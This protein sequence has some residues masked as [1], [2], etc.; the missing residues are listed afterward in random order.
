M[1]IT[2]SEGSGGPSP[3]DRGPFLDGSRRASSSSFASGQ[4]EEGG[5]GRS[6]LATGSDRA[7]AMDKSRT[8]GGGG[9][10]GKATPR[11]VSRGFSIGGI[12]KQ[13]TA[14]NASASTADKAQTAVDILKQYEDKKK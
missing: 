5:I 9:A 3:G 1:A 10:S 7:S 6:P 8:E 4:R 12:G 14:S 13:R 11:T 2:T